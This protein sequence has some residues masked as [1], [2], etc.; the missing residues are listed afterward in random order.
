MGNAV[1][2]YTP[3]GRDRSLKIDLGRKLVGRT[4]PTVVYNSVSAV[5]YGG[6]RTMRIF[7]GIEQISVQTTW[8]RNSPD[9][10]GSGDELMRNLRSMIAHLK[11]GGMV[12]FAEDED[13]CFAAYCERLPV[14]G[15]DDV[16]LN[17]R[18]TEHIAPGASLSGREIVVRSDPDRLLYEMRL[19]DAVDARHIYLDRG[20]IEQYETSR[21]VLVREAGTYPFMRLPDSA[22][23]SEP[24]THRENRVFELDL[25]LED[26]VSALEGSAV[27]NGQITGPAIDVYNQ[28]IDF[29]APNTPA[30]E[31]GGSIFSPR[32]PW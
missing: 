14:Q 32:Y 23:G 11:R 28:G 21:W 17:A 15:A 24:L 22:M 10:T 26:D 25:Q 27:Y 18:I 13:Y 4:G 5:S 16:M 12:T 3:E 1:F 19:V 2:W 6:L 9:G 8:E 30:T 31:I 29:G 7:S 20:I